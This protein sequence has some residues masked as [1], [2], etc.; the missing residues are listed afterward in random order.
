MAEEGKQQSAN[1]WPLVKFAFS[2]RIGDTEAI[3][4]EVTGL[5][6]DMQEIEYRKGN[7]WGEHKRT[8]H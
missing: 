8:T 4:Q 5:S 3:F 2:V 1:S 6:A 7:N